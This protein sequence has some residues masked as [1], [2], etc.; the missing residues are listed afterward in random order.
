VNKWNLVVDVAT[1]ENCNN[2]TLSTK[3]EHVGNE[4]PGYAA[5]QPQNGHQ[6]IKIERKVRG[7]GTMVDAAYCV[8]T[9]NQC[10]NAPCIK[11]AGNDGS[12]YKRDDGIVIIDP[13]KAKGR[14]DLVD[15]CP[16]GAIW[17][18]EEKNLPQKW[19]FD[20]HLLDQGW[21]KP[22]CVQSCPT[23]SL[24][25][26][27]VTDSEMNKI[28]E[29][30]KLDVLHPGLNTKPR[31]YYRNLYRF[32]ECFV[33]GT[34]LTDI[35]DV[36]ECVEGAEVTLSQNQKVLHRIPT[37]EFGDFKFDQLKPG[38]GEYE[39]SVRHQKFGSALTKIMLENESVYIGSLTIQ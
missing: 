6:W 14:K 21:T 31:V 24:Q 29:R 7:S 28:A 25:S 19:I 9:C 23:G 34:I 5:S 13:E 37:D 32:T 38:S 22:R 18:N 36:T 26:L 10:D 35:E 17:W 33:G 30:D 8:T 4:F 11:T 2:C 20:A 39:L 27:C 12:M 1:C 3:D 16:Y 15:S